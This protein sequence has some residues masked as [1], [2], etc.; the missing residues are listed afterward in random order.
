M[1]GSPLV[2]D[3]AEL[4]DRS[5]FRDAVLAGLERR[6]RTIPAKFL[7]DERGSALFDAICELP[8]YYLTRTETEILHRAASEIADMAGPGCAL[9]EYGSGSSV[10]SRLLIEAMRDLVAYVPVDISRQHLDAAAQRLRRDYPTLRI[11]PVCADYMTFDRLPVDLS[12]ARRRI[13]FFPGSTIGNL[14][15]AEAT[16]FLRRA[17]GLLGDTGALVLGV[18]LKKDPRRL[19]DAYN[20]AAGVTALFTLNLLR[21]MNRELDANFDLSAFAHEAFYNPVE[22][23]IEI[24]FRSLRPQTV[25]VA[26][27]GFAFAA[28]ERVHTEY[29]YKYDDAGIALLARSADFAIAETWTD[30]A[31]Q[32]AVVFLLASR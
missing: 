13:G 9:V 29:S 17:R 1:N 22:G 21:R 27:R 16:A 7:Y 24:Y 30:L 19:H 23:R 12:A 11:E 6:P 32:F 18:D 10:K 15:P 3:R 5:E 14:M 4:D 8:E 2:L 26:G 20:D 28:G 31:R 25:T